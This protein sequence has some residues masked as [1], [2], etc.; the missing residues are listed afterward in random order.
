MSFARVGA[1]QLRMTPPVPFRSARFALEPTAAHRNCSG[2]L[3]RRELSPYPP[4][5]SSTWLER[6]KPRSVADIVQWTLE[7][8]FARGSIRARGTRAILDARAWR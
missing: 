4:N 1:T 2:R 8:N 6:A 3:F 5:V 7:P